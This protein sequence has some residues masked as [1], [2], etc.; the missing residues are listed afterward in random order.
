MKKEV[1]A[2]NEKGERIVVGQGATRILYTDREPFEVV[3]I[4]T[5]NKIMVRAMNAELSPDWKPD[6]VPGGF[7]GVC[8]NQLEQVGQ[9]KLTPDPTAPLIALRRH[10]DGRW[11]EGTLRYSIGVAR[12]FYDYNF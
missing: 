6:I 8:L 12:K 2:L 9:W 11:Y 1:I 7:S 5:P 10:K 4:R 3:E